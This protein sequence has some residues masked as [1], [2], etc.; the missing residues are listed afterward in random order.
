MKLTELE[1]NLHPNWRGATQARHIFDNGFGV[2]VIT[3]S[4]SYTSES[5]PYELAVLDA[6]GDVNYDT[7]ITDDVLGHLTEDDVDELLARVED[8]KAIKE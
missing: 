7:P 4:N 8:L 1:F 6:E 5:A 2:S 3:G